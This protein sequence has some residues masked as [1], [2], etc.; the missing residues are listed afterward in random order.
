MEV[1][2][3]DRGVVY[4]YSDFMYTINKTVNG[5]HYVK[6]KVT[7]CASRAQ[8]SEEAGVT[9]THP[10]NHDADRAAIELV[11]LRA[12]LKEEALTTQKTPREIFDS[13]CRR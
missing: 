2:D 5:V 1:L 6:C 11:K 13:V 3:G 7:T 9:V 12:A 4:V 10:H 8:F